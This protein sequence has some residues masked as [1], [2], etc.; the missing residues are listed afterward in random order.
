[1]DDHTLIRIFVE[2]LG[3]EKIPGL[4][5]DRW[6]DIENRTG[7]DIDAIA[8]NLAIEHT[9][10][11]SVD[12]QRRN[13]DWFM[14]AVGSLEDEFPSFPCRL[15]ITLKY[16]AVTIGQ[17]WT[18]IRRA[19]KQWIEIT[20]VHLR[21]G[22]H[23]V[24]SIPGVP[25][26]I[27]VRKSNSRAPGVFFART[28]PDEANLSCRA[29]VQIDRKAAKLDPYKAKGFVTL[30]LLENDDVALMNE[31]V[32]LRAIGYAY[33]EGLTNSIDELW[34]ADSS[35]ASDIAFEEFTPRLRKRAS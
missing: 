23:L 22:A 5:V 20:S 21:D 19:M 3:A 33:P 32:M 26:E 9:S 35:L 4:R 25:F 14:K 18:A 1:M 24:S 2:Y 31:C 27:T 8:G 29:R 15:N 13:S 11:D 10:I 30:L 28:V 16:E 6:P 7:R 12:D 34:Y 17:D